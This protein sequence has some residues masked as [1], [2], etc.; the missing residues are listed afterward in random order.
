M[1]AG[2]QKVV[3]CRR[4]IASSIVRVEFF[5]VVSADGGA[6]D[7]LAVDFL[8][9]ANFGPAGIALGQMDGVLPHLL[10]IFGRGDVS[11]RKAKSCQT[12]LGMPVVPELK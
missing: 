3:G 11:Q 9:Q 6:A 8:P 10:P 7:P 4:M 12:I 2:A 1:V 5:G